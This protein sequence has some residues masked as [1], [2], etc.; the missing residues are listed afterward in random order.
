MKAWHAVLYFLISGLIVS[1]LTT[2]NVLIFSHEI[3]GVDEIE[4]V[5]GIFYAIVFLVGYLFLIRKYGIKS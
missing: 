5:N 3:V 1:I 4:L 2:T